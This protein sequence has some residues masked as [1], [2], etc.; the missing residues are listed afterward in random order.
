MLVDDLSPNC[1]CVTCHRSEAS[2]GRGSPE[3]GSM[4][5]YHWIAARCHDDNGSKHPAWRSGGV[6]H[7]QFAAMQAYI[8][9]SLPRWQTFNP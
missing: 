4:D 7:A 8:V 1:I 3:E 5:W 9:R 6:A 2:W